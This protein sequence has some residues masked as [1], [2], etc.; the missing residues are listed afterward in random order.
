MKTHTH[1]PYPIT[2]VEQLEYAVEHKL[3]MRTRKNRLPVTKGILKAAQKYGVWGNPLLVPKTIEELEVG[4]VVSIQ[5]V[6]YVIR[7][8][9]KNEYGGFKATIQGFM[10]PWQ[11]FSKK[12][13]EDLEIETFPHPLPIDLFP[14]LDINR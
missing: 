12:K 4:D 1:Y 14:I 2:T 10:N 5:N 6:R 9:I 13:L 7:Q 3:I 11:W 8:K